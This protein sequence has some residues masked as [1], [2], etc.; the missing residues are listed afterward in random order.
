MNFD[1]FCKKLPKKCKTAITFAY[2]VEKKSLIYQKKLEKNSD[3]ISPGFTRWSFLRFS[4]FQKEKKLFQ[5]EKNN[6]KF[7][8]IIFEFKN[9]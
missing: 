9:K 8:K 7:L 4:K 2:N 5:I 6:L 1:L 3:S